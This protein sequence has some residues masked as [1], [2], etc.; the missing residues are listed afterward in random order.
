MAFKEYNPNP[1][2]NKTGDCVIRA[3]GL[4]TEKTWEETFWDMTNHAFELKTVLNIDEAWKS[5]LIKN[6]FEWVPCKVTK[7]K[8]RPTV[9]QMARKLSDGGYYVLRVANHVVTAH[10]GHYHDL[11][12][13]GNCAVYG[14]FQKKEEQQ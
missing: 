9:A 8:K 10:G 12:D 14:Y 1:K 6:G 7:G 13:S 5:Y 11:W 4:A 2:G 3:I